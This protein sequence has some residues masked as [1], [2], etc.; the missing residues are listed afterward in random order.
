MMTGEY[1]LE[2]YFSWSSV[3]M[4]KGYATT[5]FLFVSFIFFIS[6]VLVNL[7][8]GLSVSKTEELYKE[9]GIY[10]LKKTVLQ[11]KYDMSNLPT[12]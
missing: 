2:N 4:D 12:I 7:L 11:V 10:R 6:I 9:A 5:Q 1:N 8:V 3:E